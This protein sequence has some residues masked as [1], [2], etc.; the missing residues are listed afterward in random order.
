MCVFQVSSPSRP[1]A[2]G[3]HFTRMRLAMNPVIR[4]VQAIRR[5]RATRKRDREYWRWHNTLY[6]GG[7][8]AS[9]A[10]T[11]FRLQIIRRDGYRCVNC[12]RTGRFP[13]R[14]R[15]WWEPFRPEGPRIGLQVDHILPLSRG[16]TNNPANLQTLCKSCHD[17]KTGRR[18]KGPSV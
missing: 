10:W 9:Q 6:P 12:G 11:D 2:R 17:T 16:G 18:L 7:S 3:G 14:R 4:I 1:P 5:W 8:T 13:R 15:A